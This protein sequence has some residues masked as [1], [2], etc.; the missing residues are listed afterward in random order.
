MARTPDYVRLATTAS[1]T[2]AETAFD[3]FARP[4]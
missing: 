1:R 4:S 2:L 3:Y